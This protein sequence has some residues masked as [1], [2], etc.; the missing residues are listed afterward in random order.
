MT[1]SAGNLMRIS[2]ELAG[3]QMMLCNWDLQYKS[4]IHSLAYKLCQVA[5]FPYKHLNTHRKGAGVFNQCALTVLCGLWEFCSHDVYWQH[6]VY[7]SNLHSISGDLW[8]SIGSVAGHSLIPGLAP[9]SLKR[10]ACK[11]PP[12]AKKENHQDSPQILSSADQGS[13]VA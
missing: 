12:A 11:L 8:W 5:F 3:K 2:S 1:L 4:V 9:D 10:T 6:R 13:I 7:F